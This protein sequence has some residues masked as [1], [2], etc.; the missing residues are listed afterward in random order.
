MAMTLIDPTF[1]EDVLDSV[2]TITDQ[3]E[4]LRKETPE[5][6]WYELEEKYP[7][8]GEVLDHCMDLEDV[9]QQ[10]TQTGSYAEKAAA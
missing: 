4:K 2:Q 6:M 9:Y 7:L 5:D 10:A 3:L 8:F 1:L